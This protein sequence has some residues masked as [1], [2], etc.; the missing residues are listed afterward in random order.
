MRIIKK[1]ALRA[2]FTRYPDVQGPLKAWMADVEAANWKSPQDIKNRYPSA[3]VLEDNRFVF[4]IKGN[5]CRLIVH[6]FFPARVV[7]IKFFGTLGVR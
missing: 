7:Y 2:Q 5:Q 3:S 4:D 1:K 6:I